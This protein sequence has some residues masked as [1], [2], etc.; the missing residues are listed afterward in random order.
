L[1]NTILQLDK[2]NPQVAARMMEAFTRWRKFD[3]TRQSKMKKVLQRIK[4]EPKLSND[5]FEVVNKCLG[6]YQFEGGKRHSH[7]I[8]LMEIRISKIN[9]GEQNS[10]DTI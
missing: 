2:L 3:E 4:A 8:I 1:A 6:D 10:I 5:I 7:K 9:V